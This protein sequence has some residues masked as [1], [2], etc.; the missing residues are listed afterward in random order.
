MWYDKFQGVVMYSGDRTGV[1]LEVIGV[2][3]SK[4]L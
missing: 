2:K 4:K 1:E 3:G